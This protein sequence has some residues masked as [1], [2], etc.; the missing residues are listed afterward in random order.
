[1]KLE[2]VNAKEAPVSEEDVEAIVAIECDPKVQKWVYEYAYTDLQQ[3]RDEYHAFFCTLPESREVE[4]LIAK[5]GSRVVGFLALWSRG[6]FMEHVATIGVSV[7]PAYWGKGVATELVHA[8][9]E[10]AKDKGLRRLEAETLAGNT[11]M[12]RVVERAGF[13]LECVRKNR[14]LKDGVYHDEAAYVLS[15]ETTGE[16]EDVG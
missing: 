6:A 4:V 12:R 13:V 3:E 11:A 14:V 1:M 10:L 7:H 2:I 16:G 9:I 15:L 8:A 5:H